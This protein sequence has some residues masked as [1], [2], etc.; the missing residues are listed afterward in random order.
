MTVR[1]SVISTVCEILPV[2]WS[3][4]SNRVADR[5]VEPQR[6]APCAHAKPVCVVG[7]WPLCTVGWLP[8]IRHATSR[9]NWIW[10]Q[11]A[12]VRGSA[13]T[14]T[15]GRSSCRQHRSGVAPWRAV[16]PWPRSSGINW[17]SSDQALERAPC[18]LTF[19]TS[20]TA[21]ATRSPG[22]SAAISVS[23]STIAPWSPAPGPH[24]A[25]SGQLTSG[26]QP[27]Q[28]MAATHTSWTSAIS[29]AAT[30]SR[31]CRWK[32]KPLSWLVELWNDC[33]TPSVPR[34][35]SSSTTAASSPGRD[36]ATYTPSL[37]RRTTAFPALHPAIQRRL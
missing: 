31:A 1:I 4:I 23:S 18:G 30:S 35:S 17:P 37:G 26:S 5:S 21:T 24:P 36:L 6:K 9:P 14:S 8:A 33:T 19:L 20:R 10:I 7:P 3:T 32:T 2:P 11:H 27:C 22:A 25:P 13:S 15:A 29:P 12:C 16:R 34:W 28:L